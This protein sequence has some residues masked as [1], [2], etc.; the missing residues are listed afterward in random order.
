MVDVKCFICIYVMV[1]RHDTINEKPGIQANEI[2]TE[3]T[4]LAFEV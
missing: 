3:K 2:T 4:V 1:F